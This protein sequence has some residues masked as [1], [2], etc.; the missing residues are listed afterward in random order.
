MPVED[1]RRLAACDVEVFFEGLNVRIDM[2]AG[3]KRT[4]A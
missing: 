3:F 2:T 1:Q 4:Q